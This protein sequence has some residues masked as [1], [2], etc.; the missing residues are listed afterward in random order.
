MFENIFNILNTSESYA[1][2]ALNNSSILIG[3]VVYVGFIL[4]Y[5]GFFWSFNKIISKKDFHIGFI[6][7]Y[8]DQKNENFGKIGR[9]ILKFIKYIIIFPVIIL[10]WFV[11]F[12]GFLFFLSKNNNVSGILLISA[13]MII[14]IRIFAFSQEDLSRNIAKIIPFTLL[15]LFIINPSFSDLTGFLEKFSV[16]KDLI[17]NS[18]D[19][20]IFIFIAEIV[21]RILNQTSKFLRTFNEKKSELASVKRVI[22]KT[23]KY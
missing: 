15:A 21:L 17:N 2:E 10:F 5:S 3:L 19:L 1:T 9:G 23:R 6:Q 16:I 18:L 20:M 7:N 8:F 12:A 22:R 14:A 11:V 13:S 4:V